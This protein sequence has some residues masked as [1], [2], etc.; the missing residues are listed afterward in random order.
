MK[1]P[2]EREMIDRDGS[3]VPGTR[4]A[5][6]AELFRLV[7]YWLRM[8]AMTTIGDIGNFGGSAC[9]IIAL[10]NGR[11]ARLNSDTKRAAVEE[12]VRSAMASG[13][14][15]PWSVV[16]NQWGRINKVNFRADG[17]ATP[18]WY[19]YLTEPLSAPRK[20]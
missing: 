1:F 13:A 18:G 16:P 3:I 12:F 19:C 11:T 6:K 9:I 14:D 15:A 4:L 5:G 20:I 2:N 17:A 10:G 8:S 7:R